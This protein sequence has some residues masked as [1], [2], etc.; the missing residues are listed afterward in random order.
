M[1]DSQSLQEEAI[2]CSTMGFKVKETIM[3]EERK[4]LCFMCCSPSEGMNFD[5]VCMIRQS[6]QL[7]ARGE[8]QAVQKVR[9][10]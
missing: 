7:S 1:E 9:E 4:S 2:F 5:Y 8:H 10:L 3:E 6:F